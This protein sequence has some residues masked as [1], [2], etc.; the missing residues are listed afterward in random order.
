MKLTI[1]KQNNSFFMPRYS[2]C[3]ELTLI[4][5]VLVDLCRSFDY[6]LNKWIIDKELHRLSGNVSCITKDTNNIIFAYSKYIKNDEKFTLSQE[7]FIKLVNDWHK[8]YD[9]KKEYIIVELQ[10]DNT[11]IVTSTNDLGSLSSLLNSPT[12]SS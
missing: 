2:S 8:A 1:L 5:N 4:I 7:N 3:F 6:I 10:D 9:S 12:E 11:I